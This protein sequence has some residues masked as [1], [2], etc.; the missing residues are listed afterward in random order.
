MVVAEAGAMGIPQ[1][2]APAGGAAEMIAHGYSGFLVDPHSPAS[3]AD[4]LRPLLEDADLAATFGEHARAIAQ[5]YHPDRVARQTLEVYRIV[6]EE[7]KR[8]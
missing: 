1:V 8:R 5:I 6:A 4:G 7:Y 3:I 2:V